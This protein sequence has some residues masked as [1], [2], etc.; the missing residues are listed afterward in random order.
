LVIL[1]E[2]TSVRAE[3][4]SGSAAAKAAAAAIITALRLTTKIKRTP[5]FFIP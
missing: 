1:C 4:S 3:K 2:S 5:P